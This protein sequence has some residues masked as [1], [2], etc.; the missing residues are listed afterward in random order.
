MSITDKFHIVT[1][2]RE[3]GIDPKNSLKIDDTA[4]KGIRRVKIE[5]GLNEPYPVITVE[6]IAKKLKAQIKTKNVKVKK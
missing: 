3:I 6:F 5:Y 4:I 1:I 2:N